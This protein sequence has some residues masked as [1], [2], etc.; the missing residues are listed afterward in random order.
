MDGWL[1]EGTKGKV[2][3][4]VSIYSDNL[5]SVKKLVDNFRVDLEEVDLK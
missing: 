5:R 4:L 3:A 1:V 2:Y